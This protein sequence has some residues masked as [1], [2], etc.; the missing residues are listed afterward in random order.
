[1]VVE[2]PRAGSE[3]GRETLSDP[4][5]RWGCRKTLDTSD[6]PRSLGLGDVCSP[7]HTFPLGGGGTPHTY[8]GTLRSNQRVR[9]AGTAGPRVTLLRGKT[10]VSHPWSPRDEE[11]EWEVK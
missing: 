2:R 8:S 11:R 9:L 1:M 7:V 3:D 4:Q 10:R 5:E 6:R